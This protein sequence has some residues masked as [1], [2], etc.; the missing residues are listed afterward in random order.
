MLTRPWRSICAAPLLAFALAVPYLGA[1]P[2]GPGRG[3]VLFTQQDRVT[4]FAVSGSTGI[5]EQVGT[6]TGAVTG[7]TVVSFQFNFTGPT[8]FTF[9]NQV[10]ITDLD[11]DQLRCLNV[12]KGSFLAANPPAGVGGPLEGTYEVLAASTGKYKN[13]VGRKFPYRGVAMNSATGTFGGVYVEVYRRRN[14]Q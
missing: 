5:G 11:G 3:N 14:D 10:A 9:I 12:G 2:I 7:A 4:N 13:W 8:N 6:A 1:E